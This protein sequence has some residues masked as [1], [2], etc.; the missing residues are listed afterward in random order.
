MD[1]QFIDLL[2]FFATLYGFVIAF[3]TIAAIWEAF[4]YWKFLEYSNVDTSYF[5]VVKKYLLNNVV[6]LL[7]FGNTIRYLLTRK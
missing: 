7:P 1:Q 6:R 5:S 3:A 2:I 4:K